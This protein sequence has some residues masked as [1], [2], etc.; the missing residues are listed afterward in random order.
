MRGGQP[1]KR[2]QIGS[3]CLFDFANSSFTTV[4]IT[5]V[6]SVYFKSVV[7]REQDG[8]SLWAI[9]LLIS[10]VAILFSAPLVGAMADQS[11]GK[12]R[13]LFASYLVCIACT[14]GLFLAGPE[15]WW[16]AVVLVICA[17][18]AFAT[19]ENLI[20]GFLP[21]LSSP[22]NMG[23][24][25][26]Y[27]WATGYC[28]GLLALIICLPLAMSGHVRASTLV[29]A[30]FFLVAGIPTFIWLRE[31]REEALRPKLGAMLRLGLGQVAS[32]L[33]AR[34]RH[35]Q[36]FRFLSAYTIF[37]VGIYGVIGFAGIYAEEIF[38]MNQQEIVKVFIATQIT[39]LIGALTSGWLT[40]R[41]N[42]V[43]VVLATL[44]LWTMAGIMGMLAQN[45]TQFWVLALTAGL[46]MGSSLPAARA[47]VARFSP[48][49]QSAEFFGFWGLC[50]R[51]AAILSNL[52]FLVI[53]QATNNLRATIGYFTATFVVGIF[54]L[55]RV[56]EARGLE[57]SQR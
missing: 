18:F 7:A 35:R 14:A 13:F 45:S 12:K 29:V 57:E 5:A 27:G 39:A 16:L 55:L 53:Y 51:A 54:L 4:I 6:Y 31:P 28:G 2:L 32:T 33:K 41:Y 44:I 43:A 25:S 34:H 22:E 37:N 17:N 38:D 9:A 8:E 15:L 3:W 36:F 56:D 50:A 19:G 23:R 1:S 42:C 20:A 21:Q 24:I 40:R 10:N 11:S 46:A 30:L 26:A 49:G 52:G 48:P 47:I